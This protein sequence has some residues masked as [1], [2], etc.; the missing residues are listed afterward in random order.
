MR[1]SSIPPDSTFTA[2]ARTLGIV[3]AWMTFAVSEVYAVVSGLAYASQGAA[4]ESGP[5][6]SIMALLVV[7]MGPFLVLSM[8][9]VHAYAS[10]NHK[11]YS[12]AALAFMIA[13]VAVTSCTLEQLSSMRAD[14]FLCD[15]HRIIVTGPTKL[16]GRVLDSR[17][18]RSGMALVAAALAA[19]GESTVLEIE[20]VERGYASLVDRLRSLG[21]PGRTA[22]IRSAGAR[23]FSPG[24]YSN[25][26]ASIGSSADALRAG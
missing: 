23:G 24:G 4:V 19:E 16:R 15:P 14:L 11:P 18:I 26:S 10:P 25:L 12:L 1:H 17:D 3:A 7:V 2:Q 8:V 6:L 21:R 9:A 20:T 22:G 13:C 5:F